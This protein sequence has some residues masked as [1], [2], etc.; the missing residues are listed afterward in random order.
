MAIDIRETG[1]ISN[2]LLAIFIRLLT[3]RSFT[4]FMLILLL[5][6]C[7]FGAWSHDTNP[8]AHDTNLSDHNRHSD[9]VR[10]AQLSFIWISQIE[11]GAEILEKGEGDLEN[12][13]GFRGNHYRFLGSEIIGNQDILRLEAHS[14]N[15]VS[16]ELTQNGAAKLSSAT[17]N[18]IG[19]QMAVL[20]DGKA[21]NVAT[22]QMRLGAVMI[23]TGLTEEQVNDLV[24]RF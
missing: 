12:I 10:V 18:N 6:V 2:P 24:L 4:S 21:V 13:I 23:I 8:S 15:A 20:L 14:A 5:G 3:M 19:K 22:V 1:I 9:Q 16:I 11:K 7:S 17:A